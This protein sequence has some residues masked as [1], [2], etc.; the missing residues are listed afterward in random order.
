MDSVRARRRPG[1]S[2]VRGVRLSGPIVAA[3]LLV[4]ACGSAASPQSFERPG[5]GSTGFNGGAGGAGP[6]PT[7]APS[8]AGAPDPGVQN[9]GAPNATVPQRIAW[10]GRLQ[11]QVADLDASLSAA[12]TA[13]T[14][15]GG[16]VSASRRSGGEQPV[17]SVTYRI[18]SD[19]WEEGLG[20]LRSLA[21]KVLD[22]Q[23]DSADLASQIVDVEARLRNLR[24]SEA[25][26]Q[27]IATQSTRIT[28]VLE[29]QARLTE[30]RGQIESLAAQQA[31][32]GDRVALGTLTVTSSTQVVAV[33]Q[34]AR[35][36]D[37]AREVDAA[38]ASLV[39][40]LQRVASG[41]IW[42]AIVGRR[43]SWWEWS[44]CGSRAR[45]C[46]ASR[47]SCRGS[48]PGPTRRIRA[49]CRPARRR[50]ARRLRAETPAGGTMT[51]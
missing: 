23:T 2:P 32:L 48:R 26:L 39:S 14:G 8:A 5:D 38:S 43:C 10:T 35:Q 33:T 19:R 40:F 16:F 6:F 20:A 29:V 41:A 44:C 30:V 9:P 27:Q 1:A 24:A 37:P 3:L 49:R 34:A 28:D 13:I 36:W 18:P 11:L 15:V 31:A 21:L 7:A 50:R 4:A 25:A 46:A 22:E 12:Q 45:S 47:R 51:G 17:A 42:F